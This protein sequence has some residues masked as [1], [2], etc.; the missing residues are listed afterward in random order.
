MN[1]K[2]FVREDTMAQQWK[3]GRVFT[4]YL[5]D[6]ETVHHLCDISPAYE[7]HPITTFC[8]NEVDDDLLAELQDYEVIYVY[9]RNVKGRDFP[10]P[11]RDPDD[12]DEEY[13]EQVL[14]WARANCGRFQVMP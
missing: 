3:I 14:E 6:E 8:E 4:T 5:Y 11:D 7:C 12:S 1:F 13:L 10:N 2:Y 9:C